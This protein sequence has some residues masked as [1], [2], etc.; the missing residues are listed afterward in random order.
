MYPAALPPNGELMTRREPG[1]FESQH[2][3]EQSIWKAV[4]QHVQ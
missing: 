1:L 2:F 3:F 4:L